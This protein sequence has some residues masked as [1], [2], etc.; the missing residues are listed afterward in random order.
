MHEIVGN[1]TFVA[2]L[3]GPLSPFVDV[4][5]VF[6][7][8]LGAALATLAGGLWGLPRN[9]RAAQTLT[10]LAMV[11]S[12]LASALIFADIAVE[13]GAARTHVLAP[14]IQVGALQSFWTLRLDALSSVMLMVVTGVSAM[15]HLYALGYM[16]H[17]RGIP[18][19]MAY[20]SLFTF[21]MLM[22]VTA[23]DLIQLF[24]GWEAVGVCSY[25]LIGFWYEK[26]RASAA[27][28]K[29]FVVNRIGDFG[30]ILG[31]FG[32]FALFRS[33]AFGSLFSAAPDLESA[34]YA[35][36]GLDV[37]VLTVLCLLLFVGA[38]GKSAQLG[39]HVWLPDAMEGPTPV[40]ALIHAATMVTAGVFMVARLSPL[41]EHAPGALAVVT[42]VGALTALFAGVVALAQTDIKRVIAYSTMSQLGYMFFAAGVAAYPAA[43]FHLMTHA[44]FKALL[45]LGAGAVIHA[46]AGEQ[47]LRR[48]G[49][50]ARKTPVTYVLMAIGSLA[51]AGIGV[52]GVFG[53]AGFYSKDVILEAA[54]AQGSGVG[55]F[56][57]GVGVLVA[58]L[59]A[60]YIGRL[61]VLTF[62]GKPRT[63][64]AV[65]AHAHEASWVMLVPLVPLALGAVFAGFWGEASF[66][67]EGRAAFWA[68][69]L[70]TG[71]AGD[72]LSATH[73]LAP[74]WTLLPVAAG[75][76]GLVVAFVVYGLFPRFPGWV[77][78]HLGRV[79]V[80]VA[81]AFCVDALYDAMFVRPLR[82]L[83]MFC[84]ETGDDRW[85]DGYGPPALARVALRWGQRVRTWQTGY[86]YHYVFAVVTGLVAALVFV[87]STLSR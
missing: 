4:A 53:F 78:A 22:L 42:V 81:N 39:L 40:S 55:V 23:D 80:G 61:F 69:S 48:M 18:R 25:L 64:E 76:G 8:L 62:H 59:T 79:Y 19:F 70:V 51:L 65:F 31:I 21:G 82:A 73:H 67:G 37:P 58:G 54:L 35:L 10:C 47:D 63:D 5:A 52:P 27:A 75:V 17:D 6:L 46:L 56:A 66:V 83:G 36:G 44:F 71:G 50:L 16:R 26:P 74:I 14:W 45:F 38:M 24:F 15:V 43:I 30:F 41:F 87:W 9:D 2:E 49:G 85:I 20:L 32:C 1:A 13:G 77:A 60:L 7:P 68:G 33:V 29:A 86:I 12:A 3:L 11:A 28:V 57:Y 84:R 72:P 34:T